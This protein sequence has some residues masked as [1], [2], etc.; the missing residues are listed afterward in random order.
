MR[1]DGKFGSR[2]AKEYLNVDKKAFENYFKNSKEISSIKERGRFWFDKTDL[3]TWKKLK[4]KRTIKLNRIKYEKCF[5]FA[6]RMVYG[7][8]ALH[9]IR[10][11]RSEV[12]AS[13]DVVLGILGEYGVK[14]F[15]IDRFGVEIRLDEEV[16]P[17]R[18]T[19]QDID[20]IIDK[21]LKRR[22]KIG[23]GIKSSKFKNA[24]LILKKD[25][26]EKEDRKSEVYIFTRVDLPSDH[27]F[28]MLREHSFFKKISDILCNTES[29]KKI[30]ELKD[31][32]I[33]VCGFIY[34]NELEKVTEIPGQKFDQGYRYVKSVAKLH[35]SDKDWKELLKKL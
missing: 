31:I 21:S 19:P 5:E 13:D 16:H 12:Q 9:G 23:V 25:E 3:D 27:I 32:P 14:Q 6:I 7:G 28:R 8:L 26:V 29:P 11:K 15:L 33:W 35:N 20:Y 2:E 30:K 18:I 34:R 10:G 1:A 22:P 17:G 24:F 4:E